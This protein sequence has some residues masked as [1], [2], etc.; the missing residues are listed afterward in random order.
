MPK[1]DELTVNVQAKV[2]VSDET[3]ERCLRLLEIWQ[4]DNPTKNI[5]VDCDAK[6]DGSNRVRMSI[7]PMSWSPLDEDEHPG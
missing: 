5:V 4:E 3:A 2:A 7:K 1:V 6:G